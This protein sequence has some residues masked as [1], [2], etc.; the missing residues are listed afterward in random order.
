MSPPRTGTD[1][2]WNSYFTWPWA[3]GSAAFQSCLGPCC[4]SSLKYLRSS[5]IYHSQAPGRRGALVL[6]SYQNSCWPT[7]GL[8]PMYSHILRKLCRCLG[9]RAQVEGVALPSPNTW[10]QVDGEGP[11]PYGY[12][13]CVC[14]GGR[15]GPPEG[16]RETVTD[17]LYFIH[18]TLTTRDT[19]F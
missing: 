5:H 3:M 1:G 6:G 7:A 16:P 12:G 11:S 19:S 18:S 2:T 4:V 13:W 8:S 9:A 15:E 14:M 17:M 10:L